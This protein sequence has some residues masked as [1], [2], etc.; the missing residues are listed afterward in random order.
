MTSR[1]SSSAYSFMLFLRMPT[2]L[3]NTEPEMQISSILINP[4]LGKDNTFETD[5]DFF[6]GGLFLI[7]PN[8]C[9]KSG[10]FEKC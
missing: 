3:W 8:H 9:K 1:N 6:F 4:D 2:E 7:G 5:E 10:K